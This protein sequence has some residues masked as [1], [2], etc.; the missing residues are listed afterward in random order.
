MK[1][2]KLMFS[3]LLLALT[4][5]S[6]QRAIDA[7]GPK[8]AVVDSNDNEVLMG[9]DYYIAVTS[10]FDGMSLAK[11][12]S[13][14]PPVVHRNNLSL[15]PIKFSSVADSNDNVV[16]VDT[17]LNLEFNVELNK[18]A[19][20]V[21]TIWKVEFNASMQQW[22]VTIGGD[23]SHNRFQITRACPYRKYFY[24]LRYCPYLGSIQFPCVTVCS[25][26]KN[27]LSYLALNGEPIPIV[28]GQLGSST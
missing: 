18:S 24:Q 1:I 19:C 23:R 3:S 26:F 20:N 5:I 8:N 25:L 4:V 15:L 22:L 21:P 16:R 11:E 27:G 10:P 6:F 12:A 9:F 14:P 17:N 28:L 13:C 7:Q 2:P